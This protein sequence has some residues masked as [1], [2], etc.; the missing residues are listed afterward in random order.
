MRKFEVNISECGEKTDLRPESIRAQTFT[1]K[2]NLRL[3][4]GG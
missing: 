1:S 4:A 2:R 3:D